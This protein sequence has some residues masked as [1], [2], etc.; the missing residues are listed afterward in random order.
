MVYSGGSILSNGEYLLGW[1]AN[2]GLLTLN[3]Q[4]WRIITSSFLHFE[5]FHLV[6]N[7]VCLMWFGR[8]LEKI[9]GPAAVAGA[10]LITGTAASILSLCWAP[11]HISAGASGSVL[12]IAGMLMV[13]LPY[14][15]FMLPKTIPYGCIV[16]V[17]ALTLASG[18]LPGIDA[19]AH[20]GGLG[21]GLLLGVFVTRSLRSRHSCRRVLAS[22]EL[23]HGQT[24][25]QK[26]DYHAAVQHLTVYVVSR[27]KAARGYALLGYSLHVMRE[28]DAAVQRYQ[29]ALTLD[30]KNRL[31]QTN[32]AEL[33]MLQGRT[34]L[35]VALIKSKH[36]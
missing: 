23:Y 26:R 24:A 5:V 30:P 13:V 7:M 16:L 32:L 35:A 36:A 1:G 20:V 4:Y 28:Y 11:L 6:A 15:G 3:G 19:A 9:L 25:I 14:G 17:V 18:I 33:Y 12:G 2:Y 29:Q 31:I 21:T 27:R 34:T 10:Y 8:L 22:A